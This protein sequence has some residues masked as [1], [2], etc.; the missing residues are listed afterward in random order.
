[1]LRHFVDV[2]VAH[3]PIALANRNA[4]E[5]ATEDLPDLFCGVAVGDLCGVAVNEGSVP[6]ELRHAS[7]ERATGARAREEEQQGKRFVAQHELLAVRLAAAI[8]LL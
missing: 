2:A 8:F 4:V 1:M 3:A 7:L 6:A 5:V